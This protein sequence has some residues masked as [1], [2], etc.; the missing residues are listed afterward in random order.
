MNSR[1]PSKNVHTIRNFT[2]TVASC[3]SVI[4]CGDF[5]VVCIKQYFA[6]TVFILTRFYCIH[7]IRLCSP[8]NNGTVATVLLIGLVAHYCSY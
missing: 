5:K 6:L 4:V 2:L 7:I 8:V 3:I 1:G